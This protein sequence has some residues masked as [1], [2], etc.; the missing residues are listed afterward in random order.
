[1][2][3][4]CRVRLTASPPLFKRRTLKQQERHLALT[5]TSDWKEVQKYF[6]LY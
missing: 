2:K 4:N 5:K 1:M 3:T 6:D